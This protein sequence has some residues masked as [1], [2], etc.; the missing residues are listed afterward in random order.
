MVVTVEKDSLLEIHG[1]RYDLLTQL[2]VVFIES[3]VIYGD[4]S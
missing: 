1:H 4:T 3:L 2:C